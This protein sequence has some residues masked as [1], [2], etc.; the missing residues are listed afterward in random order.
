MNSASAAWNNTRAQWSGNPRL[1]AMLWAVLGIVWLYGLMLAGDGVQSLRQQLALEQEK[2]E[3][4][5]PLARERDWVARADEASQ[6]VKALRA[7]QWP[8]GE[9]G[10]AEAAFQ[11]WVRS[12][13]G[14]AGLRIRELAPSRAAADRSAAQ[15]AAAAQRAGAPQV[16]RLRLVAEF[17]RPE[18]V[19]FLA[20]V[21]R[22]EQVVVVDRL[23]LRPATLNGSVEMDLRMSTESAP[24]PN[25]PPAGG[26]TE[27][28]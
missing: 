22:K 8:A 13:A 3:R 9:S 15:S 23:L 5:Q 26:T 21:G 2:L 17:G 4:L 12:T 1:R 7:L 18:L 16:I 14:K 27:S 10:L 24:A 6:T 20:E 28:R 25:P 11:D 19:A